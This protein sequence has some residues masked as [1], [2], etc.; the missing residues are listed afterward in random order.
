MGQ[1]GTNKRVLSVDIF[2]G[3]TIA[4]MILVNN[5][6][7]WG[8]IYP[9]FEHAKW[10]GLTPT[11]L[12]FPFFLFIVG[13]SITFAY[14]KKKEHGISVDV[15]K[16]IFS[17]TF[18]L[19]GLGL[20]LAG[21]LLS[22][23]FFKDLSTLRFPGV[24]Q[25]IGIV[26]FIS[27]FLFLY[28]NWKSLLAIFVFILIGYWY[29]MI[30]IPIGGELPLLTKENNWATIID[31]KILTLDHMWKIYDPEGLLS[32]VPAIATTVFGMFLG[33]I[34]LDKNKSE[35]QKLGLFVIIGV[36]ALVVGYVWGMYFPLNK[37]LWTSSY[38]LVTGGWASL[39]YA[40]IYFVADVLGYSNWGKPAIIFG[41][42]AITV[43]FMSGIVARIFG[44]IKLSNGK[45][46]HGNLYEILSSVISIPKLSSLIYAIF[47]I[48][49][50]Y[51]VALVMY[52]KNIFIKV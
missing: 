41:S 36:V 12:I 14:T 33:M 15:Y 47:V 25:R 20:V 2:R 32:T 5:P 3:I 35:Q 46:I 4:A 52:R 29:I 42:N 9:P 51:F 21:F 30:R 1:I 17:R 49:F 45:S 22:P 18:K 24:L 11:D 26:F 28:L 23:P 27:S 40:L 50:Y 43:F 16:K 10:H 34:L 48:I 13:M 44:M 31:Q 19:I 39:I 7:T 8:A 38:V 37:A 6:G